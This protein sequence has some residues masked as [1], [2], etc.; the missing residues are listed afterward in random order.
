M[1]HSRLQLIRTEKIRLI[2]ERLSKQQMLLKQQQKVFR[3]SIKN[4]MLTNGE[5]SIQRIVLFMIQK[6]MLWEL[7]A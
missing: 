5:D 2:S 6:G 3:R 1:I 4:R 7:S